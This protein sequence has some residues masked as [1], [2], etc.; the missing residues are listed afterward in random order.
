LA[1][2]LLQRRGDD[3]LARF[4]RVLELPRGGVDVFDHAEGLLELAH[5]G[6]ELAVGHAP[7]GDGHDRIQHAPVRGVVQR[8]ELVRE[9]GDGEAL[10]AAGRVLDEVPLPR[11][12]G[13]RVGHEPAHAVELLVARK[14]EEA[15]AGLPAFFVFLLDF[16]D[17]LA[18]EVEHAVAR[19]RLLPEVGG[20][21][22][23]ARGRHRRVPGAAELAL[24]ER[25]EARLG[26]LQVGRHI[27]EIRVRREVR[28]AAAVGEE[29][30]ARVAVG[31]VL[32]DRVL[33]VLAGER[34]LELGGEEG[35]A[36]QEERE[37]AALFVPRAVAELGHHGEQV[38]LVEPPHLL[39]QAARGPEVREPERAA[40]LLDAM[41]QH[42]ERTAPL[43]LGGDALQ[44]L[45]AHRLLAVVLR[46]PLPLL[47]LCG[48]HEVHRVARQEAQRPVVV[49]GRALAEAAGRRVAVGRRGLADG[50]RR[51]RAGVRAVREQT[52]RDRLLEG[53]L[54]DLGAYGR[55]LRPG[56]LSVPVRRGGSSRMSRSARA[57]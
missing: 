31:L 33:D 54:G 46:E 22:A 45:L 32:A 47:G 23:R 57:Q 21:V 3:R 51:A 39:V 11:A 9:P 5:R 52:A 8:R 43:D 53:A 34:V 6:L 55:L 15:L 18:D 13:A 29:R 41:A 4:E 56:A 38:G 12:P 10:A 35:D 1:N 48:E 16:V 44:K 20:R 36:V 7:V 49:L 17:E 37:I 14:D 25:E 50:V 2:E 27:D 42:S 30:L 19:P 40:G 24:V 26:A 28:E